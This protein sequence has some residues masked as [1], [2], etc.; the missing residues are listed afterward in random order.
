MGHGEITHHEDATAGG[1]TAISAA[2]A[3][4]AGVAGLAAFADTEALRSV[5]SAG[6]RG[7]VGSIA[8]SDRVLCDG[9]P[10]DCQRA[11]GLGA[12]LI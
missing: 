12:V 7:S 4:P 1:I 3:A 6:A 8:C 5:G 2:I 11:R 10:I 9:G